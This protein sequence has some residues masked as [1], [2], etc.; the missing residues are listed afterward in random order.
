MDKREQFAAQLLMCGH[1]S[2]DELL[3]ASFGEWPPK[4]LDIVHENPQR[5][6]LTTSLTHFHQ[7]SRD[8]KQPPWHKKLYEWMSVNGYAYVC[9]TRAI[10]INKGL[11]SVFG[12]NTVSTLG[13]ETTHILQGDH[14]WRARDIMGKDG[15]SARL[16]MQDT[17]SNI[18]VDEAIKGEFKQGFLCRIFNKIADQTGAGLTYYKQG[19]EVQARLHE[20]LVAGY[21]AWDRMPQNRDEFF[22]AMK[23]VGFNLPDTIKRTMESHPDKAELE[24]AF[25][26][27][28]SRFSPSYSFVSDI[29]YLE[30]NLTEQGKKNFWHTAMPR[31]YADLIEM[32]GDKLGRERMGLGLNDT[33]LLRERHKKDIAIIS[34]AGWQY[35]KDDTVGTYAYIRLD[36]LPDDR[37][38][39]LL[40]ALDNQYIGTSTGQNA[41]PAGPTWLFVSGDY[42]MQ[43]LKTCLDQAA[44][45]EHPAA[46][47]QQPKAAARKW[48][49]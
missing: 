48:G 17:I 2:V 41:P 21:P 26:R 24:K 25:P 7:Q 44:P 9:H 35:S 10:F 32:Y 49:I 45:Q 36:S 46:S 3:H 40:K 15:I 16:P 22:F 20:A 30:S 14:F 23:S 12:G 38:D 39:N 47:P 37:K 11:L 43:R 1:A 34:S 31:L 19:I 42:A 8:Q 5:V 33:H 13:H 6:N 27:T 4:G 28:K 18:A 29:K